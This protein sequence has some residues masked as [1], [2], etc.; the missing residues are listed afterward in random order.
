MQRATAS[1]DSTIQLWDRDTGRPALTL[2]GH[3]GEV[4]SVAWGPDGKR[5]A[6][7]SGDG[8]AKV[9][10]AAGQPEIPA[11]REHTREVRWVAWSPDGK[12]L[13]TSSADQT[14]KVWDAAAG[15]VEFTLR[16][17]YSDV[18]AVAWSPDGKRLASVG[19]DRTVRVWDVAGRR[20][21]L[22]LRGHTDGLD[23]VAWSPDGKRLA[24]ASWD[25]TV[26]VWDAEG[27]REVVTLRGHNH[28]VTKVVWSPDGKRLAS[29][30]WDHTVKVWDADGGRELLTLRGHSDGVDALAWSPDGRWIASGAAD[31]T[32][33]VW[34]A[35]DGGE[36][37]VLRGHTGTVLSLAWSPDSRRLASGSK[38]HALKVWDAAAGRETLSLHGH[39]EA[40]WCVAWSPDGTCLASVSPDA[41]LRLYDATRGYVAERSPRLL[42]VLDR[43][44]A[45]DPKDAKALRLRAEVR[46]RQG[47]WDGAAADVREYLA[48]TPGGPRWYA[49]DW[50]VVGPYPDDL[51]ESYPP[52]SDP[53]PARP[54]AG[55]A[56]AGELR[57]AL[58]RWQT[59]PRDAQGFVDFGALF[60]RAEHISAYALL[61]V[62][63]PDEQTAA[64]LLG[65][66]DHVRLWLNGALVHEK[67]GA[68]EAAP[69][70]DGVPVTLR[71]GWNTLLAKVVNVTGAHALYLRLSDDPV[72]RARAEALAASDHGRWDE[73]ERVIDDILAKHPDHAPTRAL[74]E[75][76][77]RRRIEEDAR[78]AAAEDSR[79]GAWAAVAADYARLVRLRPEDHWPWFRLAI[80]QAYLGHEE[81]YRRVRRG[82]LD[83]FGW[84][85]DPVIAERTAKACSL[86]PGIAEGREDAAALA[87]FAATREPTH[88]ATPWFLLARALTAYRAGRDA[89]AAAWLEKVLAT[90]GR[91]YVRTAGHF[92]LALAQHRVGRTEDARKTLARAREMMAHDMPSLEKSG[93]DWH[94]WMVCDLLRREA[95]AL[96][97]NR[98]GP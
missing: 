5:L 10:D 67:R 13:A 26:K 49:T 52:E 8:T 39:T 11:L 3:T 19:W 57:R 33:R 95:E 59:V 70:E 76:F 96:I 81:E 71:A 69:D 90:E 74:A 32:I 98:G 21:V 40:V 20:E 4:F 78:R 47:D 73:A 41:T 64:V 87:G 37:A 46:A 93:D 66:D 45:D 92:L 89:E 2:R 50:W 53:D 97:E 61:R 9:W 27:G 28:G 82:M 60:G 62:Y 24:S 86:L 1:R 48:L 6:S 44:L 29:S 84:A 79:R 15:R 54:V 65:A 56:V 35:A 75:Q 51:K 55:P 12:R 80:V 36:R 43:R 16:G 58:L 18:L 34:D 31:Q 85:R 94:D 72:D 17:H 63:C 42:P 91:G 83:R 14:I 7:A 88:P 77:L 23:A 38:D 25:H 30:S 68:R 22:A